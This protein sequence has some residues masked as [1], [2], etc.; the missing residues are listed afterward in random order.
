M[1]VYLGVNNGNGNSATSTGG[2]NKNGTRTPELVDLDGEKTNER[3]GDTNGIQNLNSNQISINTEL[4]VEKIKMKMEIGLTVTTMILDQR[5]LKLELEKT[6]K[7]MY[8]NG[9]HLNIDDHS[10]KLKEPY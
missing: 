4:K 10:L 9:Y 3:N 1:G 6:I 5:V 2:Q 8:Q 7:L